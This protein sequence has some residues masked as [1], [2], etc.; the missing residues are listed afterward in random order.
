MRPSLGYLNPSKGLNAMLALSM[1]KLG[2]SVNCVARCLEIWMYGFLSATE[3]ILKYLDIIST[4]SI[5]V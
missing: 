4:R 5:N 3:S 2:V 1:C